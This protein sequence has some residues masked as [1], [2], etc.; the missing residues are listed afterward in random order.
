MSGSPVADEAGKLLAALQQWLGTNAKV[1]AMAT[2]SAECCV[3]PLCQLIGFARTARPEMF[4]HVAGVA[5]DGVAALKA[6]FEASFEK[7][8][9]SDGESDLGSG[10]DESRGQPFS[11]VE[12]IDVED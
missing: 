12:R 1:A 3:C 9:E 7:P 5:S 10:T 6:L 4:E 11:G 2:G 8:G